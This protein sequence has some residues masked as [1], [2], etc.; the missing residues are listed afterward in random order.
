M[1]FVINSRYTDYSSTFPVNKE[2]I[3]YVSGPSN[4]PVDIPINEL[5]EISSYATFYPK[6]EYFFTFR[7]VDNSIFYNQSYYDR[8]LFFRNTANLLLPIGEVKYH[9]EYSKSFLYSNYV[10][11]IAAMLTSNR[12]TVQILTEENVSI[13]KNIESVVIYSTR[14]LQLEYSHCGYK[15]FNSIKKN[16]YIRGPRSFDGTITPCEECIQEELLKNYD[17]VVSLP[18]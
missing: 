6:L 16:I 8:L 4:T 15:N 7:L 17:A 3:T 5:T 9:Y 1:Q 2:E 11:N 14:Q 12:L 18:K 10:K 13:P